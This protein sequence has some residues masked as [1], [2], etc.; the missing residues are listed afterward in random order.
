MAHEKYNKEYFDGKQRRGVLTL[1]NEAFLDYVF[2]ELSARGITARTAIDVG[3]AYGSLAQA[4][5]DRGISHVSGVDVSAYAI[6]EGKKRYPHIHLFAED[7]DN[8]NMPQE[9][10]SSCDLI[11]SLHTFEHCVHPED[12]LRRTV[13][14]LKDGGLLCII[15]PNPRIWVGR[16]LKIFGKEKKIPVFGDET[17]VSLYTRE[18]WEELLDRVGCVVERSLGRPFYTLKFPW[19]Y[20]LLGSHVYTRFLRDSGFEMLFVCRKK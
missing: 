12:A 8:R 10:A 18:Q 6:E 2:R 3:C 13:H 16:I 20:R 17:H 15:M 11:V 14:M 5:Y 1:S 9:L 7:I 4:L 19:L